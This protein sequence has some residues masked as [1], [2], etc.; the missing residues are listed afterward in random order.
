VGA[1]GDVLRAR[2]LAAEGRDALVLQAVVDEEHV[3]AGYGEML[4][5][6]PCRMLQSNTTTLPARAM[7]AR[8]P[9]SSARRRMLSWSGTPYSCL[10]SEAL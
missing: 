4:L 5:A 7:A 3:A 1:V 6:E 9:R 2:R 8:M 10:R